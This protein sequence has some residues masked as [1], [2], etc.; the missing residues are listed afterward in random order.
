PVIIGVYGNT[1]A[2]GSTGATGRSIVSITEH[3]LA[4]SAATGVTRSTTGWSTNMQSTTTTNKYLWNYETITWSSAPTTTYVETIS[5]GVDAAT[6]A[7]RPHGPQG[8]HGATGQRGPPGDAGTSV[9]SVTEYYL[10]TNA[11]SGV[12][13]TT[14][15]WTTTMQSMTTTNKYLWN[16]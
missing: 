13:T 14:T 10:A 9:T 11:A 15:G 4:T 2:T 8:P 3:Y 16:Y 7:Q 1:G 12:S 6:G 5:V